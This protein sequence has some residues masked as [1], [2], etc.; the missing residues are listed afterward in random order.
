M[1]VIFTISLIIS[2]LYYSIS[3]NIM[4]IELFSRQFDIFIYMYSLTL[5]LALNIGVAN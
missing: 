4:E 5:S 2:S 1:V 3:I